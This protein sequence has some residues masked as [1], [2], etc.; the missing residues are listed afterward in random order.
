MS[1]NRL[2]VSNNTIVGN[3]DYAN[4]LTFFASRLI[5]LSHPCGKLRM[6]ISHAPGALKP[7]KFHGGYFDITIVASTHRLYF[8]AKGDNKVSAI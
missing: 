5:I 3:N 2:D 7:S 6:H 1:F 8:Y 4:T